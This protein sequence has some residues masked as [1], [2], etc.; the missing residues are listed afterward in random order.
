MARILALSSW[1]SAGHV[2]LSAA[3]P[4]LQALGHDVTQLPSVVLSNQPGFA[5]IAG[6]R[7]P[8][9]QL[10]AM[11]EALDGNGW[12]AGHD[13]VLTGYLPGAA[14]VAVAVG[15]V[16]RLRRLTV[17]PRVVVDPILGDTDGGLYLDPAAAA[18]IRDDL[19]PLADVLTP[20]AFELGWLTRAPVAT[21]ADAVAAARRLGARVLVTS[22]PIEGGTGVLDVGQG[23]PVLYRAELVPDVPHGVGD[24]FSALV[25]AGLP[26][27]A[28]VGH[29]AALAAASAGRPHLSLIPSATWTAAPAVSGRPLA[30]AEA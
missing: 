6:D 28:A 29:L 17:P 26:T 10:A 3:V 21:L 13:A 23:P 12:L 27:G 16:A 30:P 19:V 2:G 8:P 4:A 11:I 25:A 24:V 22:P 7:I 5:H 14:H 18:A 15:L 9:G 1:T 20:N